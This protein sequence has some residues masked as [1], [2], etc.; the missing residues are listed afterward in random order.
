MHLMLDDLYPAMPWDKIDA[1]VFDVGNVL[2]RWDPEEILQRLLPDRPD[3]H[4]EL[5]TR[6]LR[7]PYWTMRDRGSIT[8][9]EAIAAMSRTAPALE[10][11]VRRI[12][13]G[14]GD[15]PEIPEGIDVLQTCKAHGKQVFALSNYPDPEF[16]QARQSH[17][18]FG[19]FDGIVVSSAEKIIKP[20]LE[21]YAHLTFRH[22]LN[23]ARTLF[24]DDSPANVE[25]ALEF[26][27]QAICFDRPGKLARFFAD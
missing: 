25:A 15:L 7:S 10:P 26:G 5:L 17:A 4:G 9:E 8:R 16:T 24:I 23:P 1:V 21:I 2:L 11:C 22:G 20:S 27:L 14:W 13:E 19:L 3:L 12:M 6:V 18:F